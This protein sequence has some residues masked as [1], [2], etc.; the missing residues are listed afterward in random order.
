MGKPPSE[1]LRVASSF[2]I[3]LLLIGTLV[4]RPASSVQTA[5]GEQESPALEEEIEDDP[6]DESGGGGSR[7]QV[8]TVASEGEK[9]SL[10][11]DKALIRS[12]QKGFS[13]VINE[14]G[15]QVE[16][17]GEEESDIGQLQSGA[18][19]GLR[20][21]GTSERVGEADPG[22]WKNVYELPL[23]DTKAR[24]SGGDAEAMYI[25]GLK[26][27]LGGVG[28]RRDAVAAVDMIVKAAEQG[29]EHAQSALAFL[30]DHGYG[31]ER[32]DARAFLNHHF[33]AKGGSYQSKMALAYNYVRQQVSSA[34]ISSTRIKINEVIE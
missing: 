4:A 7:V 14:G 10:F 12:G 29:H 30:Q 21:D 25:L 5:D 16:Q 26:Q 13:I 32:D 17:G 11:V 20:E 19:E 6:E 31:V 18:F 2:T 23:G 1:F 33:A 24:A 27:L 34:Y 9:V 22:A 28:V 15:Q 8:A 3:F